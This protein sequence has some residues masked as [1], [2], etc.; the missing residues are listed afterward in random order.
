MNYFNNYKRYGYNEEPEPIGAYVM[1]RKIGNEIRLNQDFLGSYGIFL[2]ESQNKEYFALSNSFLLLQEFLVGKQNIS[3]NK[4]FADNLLVSDLCSPSIHETLINEIIKLP[5]NTIININIENKIL[6]VLFVDYQENTIPFESEEG[7]KIIDS[8]IDKWGYI[9]RSLKNKTDN[10]YSDL[11]GGFDTRVMLSIL[12]SSGINLSHILI[13]SATDNK[14]GHDE[15]F[16]IAS[17][18]SSKFGFK[19]NNFILNQKNIRWG[20][21]NTLFCTKYSK[22][23]FHKEFYLKDRFYEFPRFGFT[24]SGGEIIRGAPGCPIFQYIKSISS[25]GKQIKGHEE[26]FFIS[27][28]KLC[29]RS[30]SILKKRKTFDNDYEISSFLYS[31]GR[32]RNHFGT[33]AVE[34]FIPNIYILQPLIDPD[35]KKIKYD[36]SRN[37]SH[38]LIA[39]I[40]IRFGH[41]LTNFP[42]EGKRYINPESIKK[43]KIL[44]NKLNPFIIKSDYNSNFFIDNLRI[45][46][47]PQSNENNNVNEY[48]RNV[49]K[50]SKFIKIIN[51]IY[52]NNVYNWANEYRNKSNYF[53][54]RHYYGLYAIS[55]IYEK[56]SNEKN[57]TNNYTK[58]R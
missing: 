46:P 23:G 56:I 26:E 27:S 1:I 57:T 11:S 39:Y 44:N 24:G 25:K 29:N 17:N 58:C 49:F 52:D 22:L 21:K 18:I 12:V 19:L 55:T 5:S 31:K 36:I 28:M 53:P 7:L 34:N 38:D 35:I 14:H 50:S 20:L 33:L 2:Y 16:T 54:L 4:D 43:A 45:S 40:Y 32:A 37:Q 41:N 15:D 9:I 10:I 51:E 48:L 3:I 13:N 30:I 6:K 42:I 47:V 8:W